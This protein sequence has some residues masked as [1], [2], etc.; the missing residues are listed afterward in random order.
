M[1]AHGYPR[2]QLERRNWLNLNGTW[3]FALDHAARWVEPQQVAWQT[4][5]QVPFAP[6]TSAS[7]IGDSGFYNACWYRRSFDAP[8]LANDERLMLHFGAV[9]YTVAA[10]RRS[11]S[12]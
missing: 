4:Q 11:A 1:E 7:G 3:D 5:I 9:D 6:E 12:M 10:T 8:P 2:P